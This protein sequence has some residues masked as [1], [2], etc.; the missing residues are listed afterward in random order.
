V[1]D[2]IVPGGTA[3]WFPVPPPDARA[4]MP[5]PPE[6]DPWIHSSCAAIAPRLRMPARYARSE[7]NSWVP[8]GDRKGI[9]SLARAFAVRPSH[10]RCTS[11]AV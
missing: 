3:L 6:P 11:R 8:A 4:A 10:C 7:P 9:Q 1:D 2:I 5:R